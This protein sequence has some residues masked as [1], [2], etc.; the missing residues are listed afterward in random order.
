[1]FVSSILSENIFNLGDGREF[2]SKEKASDSSF[3]SY[4]NDI[5]Y[6]ITQTG[7]IANATFGV[8]ISLYIFGKTVSSVLFKLF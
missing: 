1:M 7:S 2:F 5:K 3:S 8:L 6:Y 4:L